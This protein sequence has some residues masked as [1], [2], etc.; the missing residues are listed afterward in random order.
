MA[1]LPAAEPLD[2]LKLKQRFICFI[3]FFIF[4]PITE[5]EESR[6]SEGWIKP[7]RPPKKRHDYILRSWTELALETRNIHPTRFTLLFFKR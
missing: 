1:E 7:P 4:L 6:R 3:Y 5:S 2:D